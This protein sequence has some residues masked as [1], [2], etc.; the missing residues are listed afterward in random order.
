MIAS[1]LLMDTASHM[2]VIT[3]HTHAMPSRTLGDAES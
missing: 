3:S 2:A 1:W